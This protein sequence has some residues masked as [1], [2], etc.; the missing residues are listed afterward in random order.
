[1]FSL[2]NLATFLIT[3]ELVS[4]TGLQKLVF[5]SFIE[6]NLNLIY[7]INLFL[8]GIFSSISPIYH[9]H[10]NTLLLFSTGAIYLTS[11]D[12]T[13]LRLFL[14]HGSWVMAIDLTEGI[15]KYSV[16]IGYIRYF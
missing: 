14:L 8:P 6:S 12:F 2:I 5:V 10:P 13:P 3:N 1:M 4:W 7:L 11:G 9:R 15:S 16:M